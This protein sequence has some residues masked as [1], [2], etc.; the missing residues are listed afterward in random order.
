MSRTKNEETAATATDGRTT[1][2]YVSVLLYK[3]NFISSTAGILKGIPRGQT[4]AALVKE[5]RKSHPVDT[6]GVTTADHKF[7]VKLPAPDME[8]RYV[9]IVTK[10]QCPLCGASKM[11]STPGCPYCDEDVSLTKGELDKFRESIK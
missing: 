3:G 8:M 2:S 5:I 6:S 4:L 10:R 9:Q 11:E 7:V 1:V